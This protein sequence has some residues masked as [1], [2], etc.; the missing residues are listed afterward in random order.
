M[1]IDIL[2]AIIISLGFYL[3]YQRGLIKTIFDTLSL[4]IGILAAL[5]LSPWVID[6]LQSLGRT[7]RFVEGKNAIFINLFMKN[8][9]EIGWLKKRQQKIFNVKWIKRIEDIK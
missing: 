8:S 5:K 4:M 3:G 9:V 6:A 7:I 1:I 2:A